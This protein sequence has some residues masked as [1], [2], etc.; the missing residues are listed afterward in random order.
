VVQ[1]TVSHYKIIKKLGGGGMGEVYKAEDTRLGR[2]VALKFLPEKYT[3]DRLALER[4]EREARAA[5]ALDHPNICAIYDIG[6]YERQP[7]IVMQYLKGRTLRQ[8]IGKEPLD[9]DL[10]IDI[11]RQVATGLEKAHEKGIIHR[12]IKPANIIIT[13]DGLAKIV[14]FGLAKLGAE[15]R[16]SAEDQRTSPG[17]AVGTT[18]YMSP[19]QVRGE[20]LT[21]RSDLFSLGV[22]LY[23]AATGRLPYVGSTAGAVYDEIL[24]K[25]PISPVRINPEIPDE[26]EHI[27]NKCLEKDEE[28]RYQSAS[29]LLADLKRLAR[30]SDLSLTPARFAKP[31]RDNTRLIAKV[32]GGLGAVIVLASVWWSSGFFHSSPIEASV[33]VVPFE[34]ASGEANQAALADGLT[35]HIVARLSKISGL[36][37]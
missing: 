16:E 21:A 18:L 2:H 32:L 33:G 26:L 24:H 3:Q 20:E 11:A 14:D 17:S 30:D 6:E 28:L 22:I 25:T 5:S 31:P 29:E 4:F 15:R 19:E 23:E 9:T 7:Y 12:D 8:I 35:E 1:K 13:E 36:S 34:N 10:L 27:I 37:G